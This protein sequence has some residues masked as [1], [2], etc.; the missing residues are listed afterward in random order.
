MTRLGFSTDRTITEATDRFQ[1]LM[2]CRM[3]EIE[4]CLKSLIAFKRVYEKKDIVDF[5][6]REMSSLQEDFASFSDKLQ[7]LERKAQ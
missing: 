4:G 3:E 6:R 7:Q 1:T 5:V 2:E